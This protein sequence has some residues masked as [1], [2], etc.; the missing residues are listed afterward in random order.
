M[1]VGGK[2]VSP[3]HRPP[4]FLPWP[5]SPSGPS[6]LINEDSWSHSR[7]TT[8]S[9]TPLDEWSA[10]SRDLYLPTHNTHRR[11]TSMSP[12]GFEPTVRTIERPQTH[13]LNSAATA[14]GT[15]RLYPQE[16]SLV[17]IFVKGWVDSRSTVRPVG[18]R[19]WKIPMAP[20]GIESATFRFVSQCLNQLHH[21]D[22]L[23]YYYKLWAVFLWMLYHLR[24]F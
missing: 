18:L 2:V 3:T 4:F 9:T 1:R 7:H 16:I 17:L 19:Q 6:L 22:R 11:Q 23:L 24:Y 13:A 20:S 10:R 15:G 5:N 12:E 21:C 14:I 8:F